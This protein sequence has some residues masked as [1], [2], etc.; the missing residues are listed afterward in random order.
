[1]ASGTMST[2]GVH[3]SMSAGLWVKRKESNLLPEDPLHRPGNIY[4]DTWALG[5]KVAMDFAIT[6]PLQASVVTAAANTKLV[7][8]IAYKER[9][10]MD[11][12]TTAQAK[13]MRRASTSSPWWLNLLVAR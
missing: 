9:E 3:A 2:I 5:R 10:H 11:R 12:E 1:M 6:S 7:A 8:A 4:L 13:A